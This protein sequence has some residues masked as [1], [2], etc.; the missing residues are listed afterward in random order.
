MFLCSILCRL[1]TWIEL[2]VVYYFTI[3]FYRRGFVVDDIDD[4]IVIHKDILFKVMKEGG[5]YFSRV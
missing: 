4:M 5:L 3:I 1:E 2:N